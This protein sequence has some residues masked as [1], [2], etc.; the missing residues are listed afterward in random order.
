MVGALDYIQDGDLLNWQKVGYHKNMQIGIPIAPDENLLPFFW[1]V[2][3]SATSVTITSFELLQIS[4][5][6]VCNT[7][8]LGTS[9]ISIT[10]NGN[11]NVVVYN[12]GQNI[13][14]S[15]PTYYRGT[16]QYKVTISTGR[17]FYSELF[18]IKTHENTVI[19]GGDFNNDFNDDFLK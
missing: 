14:G 6:G 17:V 18:F 19:L 11:K 1:P 13:L 9:Y 4:K 5:D 10:N 7:Y 3:D 15:I 12:S 8:N 2:A 16:Y